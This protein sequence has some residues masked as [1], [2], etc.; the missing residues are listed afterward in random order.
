V[1]AISGLGFLT[2]LGELQIEKSL[3]FIHVEKEKKR[4]GLGSDGFRKVKIDP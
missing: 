1:C 3:V 4:D 2:G